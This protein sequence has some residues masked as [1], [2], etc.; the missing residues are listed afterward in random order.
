MHLQVRLHH[1]YC[2]ISIIL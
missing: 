1:I 2:N